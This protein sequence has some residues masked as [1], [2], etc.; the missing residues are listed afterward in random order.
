MKQPVKSQ[1]LALC[2]LGLACAV[3]FSCGSAGSSRNP[4]PP[5]VRGE[6]GH[7][8][9]VVRYAPPPPLRGVR[10]VVERRPGFVW[11]TGHWEYS[12]LARRYV[13]VPGHYI[14]ARPGHGYRPGLWKRT[15]RGWVWVPP[16]WR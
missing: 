4:P 8:E 3:A 14:Q 1:L 13:W 16:R 15:P 7:R 9:V 2:L 5:G 6:T 11:V 12:S 10:V